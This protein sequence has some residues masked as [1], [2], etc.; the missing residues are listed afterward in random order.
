[1]YNVPHNPIL[2]IKAPIVEL[3]KGWG[4]I[5]FLVYR[6]YRV[7]C[8]GCDMVF[9]FSTGC[10]N[11]RN[12]HELLF[13]VVCLSILSSGRQA[14]VQRVRACFRLLS[15]LARPSIKSLAAVAFLAIAFPVPKPAV[16]LWQRLLLQ[17]GSGKTLNPKP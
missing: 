4:F 11:I 3:C 2:I 5:R 1:M 14:D 16:F 7:Y 12:M 10:G 8:S 17:T 9:L 6:V 15:R 13:A